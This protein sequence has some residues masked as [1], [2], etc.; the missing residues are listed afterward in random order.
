[1]TS[2][3]LLNSNCKIC[4]KNMLQKGWVFSVGTW[5]VDSLTS[6]ADEMVKVFDDRKVDVAWTMRWIALDWGFFDAGGKR[7][8]LFWC[9]CQE[10]TE[11]VGVFVAVKWVDRVIQ[12]DTYNER[13]I[14]V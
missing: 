14:V 11:G 2:A 3:L 12:T 1:M 4:L 5:N 9:G 6:G 13:I 7:Y 10:K 8:K